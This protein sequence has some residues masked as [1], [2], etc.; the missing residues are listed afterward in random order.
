MGGHPKRRRK[1]LE[2]DNHT[3]QYCG[4]PADTIDHV[5]PKSAKGSSAY[6]NLV[7]ACEACN[8]KKKNMTVLEFYERYYRLGRPIW[9]LTPEEVAEWRKERQE[10]H[11]DA[12]ALRKIKAGLWKS[13]V[14]PKLQ[15]LLDEESANGQT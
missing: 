10:K 7:A 12:W 1:V 9:K 15:H 6:S 3:C 8:S 11:W 5:V 13:A 2:R 14:P 4:D